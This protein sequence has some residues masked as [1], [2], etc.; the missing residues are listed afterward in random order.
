MRFLLDTNAWIWLFSE[1]QLIREDVRHVLN[2]ESVIGLSPLS[3]IEVAQKAAKGKLIFRVA[4]DDWVLSAL[5]PQR[6]HLLPLTPAIAIRAY[7]WPGE[8]HGDPA[9]RI[10]A[11]TAA[12]HGLT[13]VTSD[14]KL[15]LRGDIQTLSTR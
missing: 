10:I 6:L 13:L 12:V 15:R 3:L 1:P 5:P 8:F 4:L 2:Q 11:A 9:D 7:N 14:E